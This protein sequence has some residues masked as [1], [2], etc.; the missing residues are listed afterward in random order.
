MCSLGF[1]LEA[2]GHMLRQQ[3]HRKQHNYKAQTKVAVTF[4]IHEEDVQKLF[5]MLRSM[6]EILYCTI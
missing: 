6:L 4:T 2:L 1:A 3:R 5:K